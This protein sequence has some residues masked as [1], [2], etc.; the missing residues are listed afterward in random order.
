MI[1]TALAGLPAYLLAAAPALAHHRVGHNGG[2]PRATQV[3]EIDASAGLLA[4][5]A[6]GAI[7]LLTWERGR[8]RSSQS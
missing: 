6:V 2:P 8:R 1:K 7:L 5:A 3:P 4:L